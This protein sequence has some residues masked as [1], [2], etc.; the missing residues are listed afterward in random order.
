MLGSTEL[1]MDGI[2][3]KVSQ[4]LKYDDGDGQIIHGFHLKVK[5]PFDFV[6]L[7]TNCAWCVDVY[8]TNSAETQR[9]PVV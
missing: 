2:M 3:S 5:Y 1:Q 4:S 9:D 7:S 6:I 8:D